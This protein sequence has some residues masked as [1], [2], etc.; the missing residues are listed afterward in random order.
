MP[1]LT[2][3]AVDGAAFDPDGPSW[4]WIPDGDPPGFGLRLYPS[5][6]KAFALR[7]R[8]ST[9]RQRYLT[10]APYPG[11][12]VQEARSRA[13]KELAGILDGADP[14]REKRE[15]RDE[16]RTV[17]SLIRSWIREYARH[18]RRSW[19]EDQRRMEAKVLPEI[20]ARHLAELAPSS[21]GRL[22]RKVGET[23]PVEANRCLETIRAA[24]RWAEKEGR[25]PPGCTDPTRRIQRF[26]EVARDRWLRDDE[27]QRL[28]AATDQEQDPHA[29]IAIRLLVLTGLRKNELLRLRWSDV[30]LDR[31]ELRLPQTKSGRP[32][33]RPLPSA[34][35][36]AINE[37]PRERS[38]WLFPSPVDPGAPRRD[39][40]R[41]WNR[42]RHRAG[43]TDVTLHDLRRT[44]GSYMAQAGVPLQVIQ[45][46]LGHSHP[47]ITRLYA[48]L[49]SKNEREALEQVADRVSAIGTV[50]TRPP[51]TDSDQEEE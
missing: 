50:P 6:R 10:I 16:L 44:C 26:R 21:L 14:A 46:V 22:H 27:L 18:H 8:T 11:L 9:G 45:Q 48:R 38:Q 33:T 34:A 43:L 39:L 5:G 37:L 2:K 25:L 1:K 28:L 29:R 13:R 30:D 15:Q 20:G 7:Y 42:I 31:Q 3:R 35:I 47:S 24:W 49:S 32:Q 4:Q 19:G 12:T 17:E 36:S 51:G 41:S 23:A 40:K